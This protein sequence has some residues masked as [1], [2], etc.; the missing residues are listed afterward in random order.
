MNDAP[1]DLVELLTRERDEAWRMRD[2]EV[3]NVQGMGD[4]LKVVESHRKPNLRKGRNVAAGNARGWGLEL[5]HLYEGIALHGE[6]AEAYK[7][8][9]ELSFLGPKKLSNL[10]L[11]IKYGLDGIDGDILELG[12]YRGGSALFMGSLLKALGRKS[13]VY[14]LDTFEGMPGTDTGVDTFKPG[15]LKASESEFINRRNSLGLQDHVEVVKG[16]F[17]DTLP[18]LSDKKWS[19]VHVDCDIY[20]PIV[21]SLNH[22][23]GHLVPGAYVVFD[24]C[25]HGSCLGAMEAVEEEYIQK[26]KLLAEQAFPHLVYR[27]N[28][29]AG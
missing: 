23:D 16:L 19:L 14:A 18:R 8:A 28:G 26:R 24:D 12:A 3:A 11:I 27:P 20:Q 17:E 15:E 29:A 9:S 7:I 22:L 6:F 5:G 21:W 1:K 4:L 10:F 13:K 2:R 25:L